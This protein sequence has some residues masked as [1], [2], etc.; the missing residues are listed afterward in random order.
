MCVLSERLLRHGITI[1]KPRTFCSDAVIASGSWRLLSR[2]RSRRCAVAFI[3]V[4]RGTSHKNVIYIADV[5][6]SWSYFSPHQ[7]VTVLLIR[8]TAQSTQL[9]LFSHSWQQV[10]FLS[11]CELY[12]IIII[13]ITAAGPDAVFSRRRPFRSHSCYFI[14]RSHDE[15]VLL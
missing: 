11:A 8:R 3:V 2:A 7:T 6:A 1:A 9:V 15:I 12:V 14:Y 5:N 13:R 10:V 4:R